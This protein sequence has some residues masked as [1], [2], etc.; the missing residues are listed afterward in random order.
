MG[1]VITVVS[2]LII[3]YIFIDLL[4]RIGDVQ[5]AEKVIDKDLDAIDDQIEESLEAIEVN[6]QKQREE[7]SVK[8]GEMTAEDQAQK[9]RDILGGKR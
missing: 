4:R 5:E 6:T 8:L 7:F 9:V 2:L 1:H 3:F